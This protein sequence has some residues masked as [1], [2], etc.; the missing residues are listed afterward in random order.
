M[1]CVPAMELWEL[2]EFLLEGGFALWRGRC[3]WFFLGRRIR[4]APREDVREGHCREV[5]RIEPEGVMGMRAYRSG[6]KRASCASL[7]QQLTQ[8]PLRDAVDLVACSAVCRAGETPERKQRTI[9]LE[10]QRGV[11]RRRRRGAMSE[12][13]CV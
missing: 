4:V 13:D 12:R 1:P 10:N 3:G 6:R 5:E 11:K 9:R 2:V 8:P 7:H